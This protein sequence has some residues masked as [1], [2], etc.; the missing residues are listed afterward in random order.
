MPKKS[1][2]CAYCE[3]FVEK[4]TKEHVVP[5]C[6]GG[7]LKIRVCA[8]CNNARGCRLDDPRFVSWRQ[9]NPEVFKEAVRASVDQKQTQN[10]LEYHGARKTN[11][12]SASKSIR[13]FPL[14]S[15]PRKYQAENNTQKKNTAKRR[16]K[17]RGNQRAEKERHGDKSVARKGKVQEKVQRA[18]VCAQVTE[19]QRL[20]VGLRSNHRKDY[21]RVTEI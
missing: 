9:R 20:R 15:Q 4:L 14:P 18:A 13:E 8:S 21:G 17:Y 16:A 11:D 19:M 3:T 12:K 7:R 2:I 6:V 10:W 1:G 5:R